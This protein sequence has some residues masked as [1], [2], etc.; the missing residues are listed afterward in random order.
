MEVEGKEIE[1][2]LRAFVESVHK[3]VN[4]VV[5]DGRKQVVMGPIE[6]ELAVTNTSHKKG[7]VKILIADAKG[8]FRKEQ[9]SKAKFKV[10]PEPT[11]DMVV[12]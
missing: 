8:D 11:F 3:G 9:V 5:V 12:V 7:G 6:F 2:Y 1:D 10:G 4:S